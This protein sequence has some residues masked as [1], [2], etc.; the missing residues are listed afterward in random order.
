MPLWVTELADTGVR[1]ENRGH[2]YPCVLVVI[3]FKI[4]CKNGL[5]EILGLTMLTKF[6]I[7]GGLA[8]L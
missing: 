8:H 5:T 2:Y 3:T 6:T 7:V 1:S 4:R